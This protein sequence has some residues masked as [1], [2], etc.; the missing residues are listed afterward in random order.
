MSAGARWETSQSAS[1]SLAENSKPEKGR[2]PPDIAGFRRQANRNDA[3]AE[4]SVARSS[5]TSQRTWPSRK[6]GARRGRGRL[7]KYDAFGQVE[8]N[9]YVLQAMDL[10]GQRPRHEVFGRLPHDRRKRA[11]ADRRAP[12]K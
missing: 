8:E 4:V 9:A 12:P 10:L 5:G 2:E 11:P 6:D 1:T 3:S 7:H